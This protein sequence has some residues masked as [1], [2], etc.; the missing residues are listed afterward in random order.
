MPFT[1]KVQLLNAYSSDRRIP[2]ADSGK[3]HGGHLETIVL[4]NG[5]SDTFEN[6]FWA[7]FPMLSIRFRVITFDFVTDQDSAPDLDLFCQQ[8]HCVMMA[9]NEGQQVHLVGHSFGAVVA[10]ACAARHSNLIKSLTL[11]AGW[12]KTDTHQ[13]IGNDIEH[14][15]SETCHQ[16]A[17]AYDV[18]RSYSP[19][20]IN[21][22][23][24]AEISALLRAVSSRA[25]HPRKSEILASIDILNE[26]PNISAPTLVV[27]CTWDSVAPIRHSK[28]LF[29]GIKNCRYAE[30]NSGH[31]VILER[32]AEL[33]RTVEDFI[34][35]PG[36]TP[37]GHV[38]NTAH[39]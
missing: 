23:N 32:P 14:S 16:S 29:G 6:N 17:Y 2:Y 39:A 20:F 33:L 36:T 31:S 3:A 1:D 35:S 30:I 18:L 25:V 11:V 13:R 21:G 37:A 38:Y 28:L 7:L 8:A 26:I 24:E 10:A 19:S 4:L 15:L 5:I 12:A 22:K 27:G 9:A 34:Q